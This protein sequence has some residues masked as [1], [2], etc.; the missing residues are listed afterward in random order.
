MTQERFKSKMLWVAI[1]SAIAM[2]MTNYGL[3]DYIGM[4]NE[5]FTAFMDVVLGILILMGILN[6]PT[7]GQNW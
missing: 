5:F 6:N 1:A 4:T 3:W 2:L 7:D